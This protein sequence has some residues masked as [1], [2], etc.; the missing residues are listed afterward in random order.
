[1]GTKLHI[2]CEG[3][4]EVERGGQVGVRWG[5]QRGLTGTVLAS[6]PLPHC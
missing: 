3:N 6:T 4:R 5:E 1:M 2:N